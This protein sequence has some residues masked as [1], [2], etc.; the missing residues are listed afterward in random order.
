MKVL[1]FLILMSILSCNGTKKNTSEI[2]SVENTQTEFKLTESDFVIMTFN[3]EWYWIFKNAKPTELT[4]SEL[5]EIEEILK[6]AIIE[7]NKNQKIGL[8]EHN[9]KYP[10]YQQTE[11]GFELKLDGYKR[12]YVPIIN[13]KGEKEVWINFF[14]DDFGTNNWKTEIALVEDGGNCYYNIKINLKTKEY[15]ELGINGNA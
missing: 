11:T 8:I 2:K 9:K 15:Y 5:F 3:S 13:E 7:N 6:I 10:E 4:Q 12:Q 1:I 14:C